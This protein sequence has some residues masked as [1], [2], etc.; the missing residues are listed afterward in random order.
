MISKR[1]VDGIMISCSDKCSCALNSATGIAS[2]KTSAQEVRVWEAVCSFNFA[3]TIS[4]RLLCTEHMCATI[5]CEDRSLCLYTACLP[6]ICQ[7]PAKMNEISAFE[8]V[9]QD[10]ILAHH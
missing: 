1:S 8:N 10:G 7:P 3:S 9:A 6:S 5:P 4:S 2:A